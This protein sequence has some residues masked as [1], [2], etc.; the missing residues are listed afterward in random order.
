MAVTPLDAFPPELSTPAD[1]LRPHDFYAEM[2]D[3]AP[4]RYDDTRG[5]WD[6]F[7]FDAVR[8]VA[9]DPDRFSS[10]VDANPDHVGSDERSS[11]A[12]SMLHA[13]P[14]RHDALRSVVDHLFTREA[15]APLRPTIEET[16]HGLLDEV[17]I[18][19][20]DA[21]V[22]LVG[23][24][25]FPLTVRTIAEV[26]GVPESDRE[27][28]LEWTKFA[29]TGSYSVDDPGA[30]RDS[31]LDYFEEFPGERTAANGSEDGFAA[32]VAAAEGLS[33]AERRSLFSVV[34]L[35]GLSMTSLVSNAVWSLDEADL[36][37]PVRS[38]RDAVE[39]AVEETLRY[40]SP[41]QAHSR[42]ATAE[43]TVAGER[44]EP[45]EKLC[46]WFGAANHDPTVFDDPGTF[47]LDRDPSSHV[48]FG[49]GTHYCLGASLARLE[50]TVA[51]AALFERF[52]SLTVETGAIEPTES[53]LVYGP[54]TLPVSGT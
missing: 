34:L 32:A 22:D 20:T 46:V 36:V 2:H 21:T 13:D 51:I 50:A 25:A 15:V 23:E 11:L 26:L 43:V 19:A 10:R 12:D 3:S 1:R 53:M 16:A 29:M 24:Y 28:F 47:D 31:L 5:C 42:Y 8:T 17:A 37:P 41:V 27:R 18:D 14:P 35:G 52:D 33:P 4:I 9:S 38:D 39:R 48:A 6:V 30:R 7:G 40:R 45:G 54:S 49:H 44:I